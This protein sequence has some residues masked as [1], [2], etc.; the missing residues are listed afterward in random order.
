[1][2]GVV[3]APMRRMTALLA[4]ALCAFALLAPTTAK[5]AT[6]KTHTGIHLMT[7]VAAG[8]PHQH[9]LTPR[10]DQPHVISTGS[11]PSIRWSSGTATATSATITPSCTADSPRMRGP[12]AHGCS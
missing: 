10:V 7:A 2:D 11:A 9:A 1:M 4:T 5:A 8:N 3:R 12:P 6:G